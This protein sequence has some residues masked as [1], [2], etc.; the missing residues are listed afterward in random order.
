MDAMLE[1]CDAFLDLNLG[2]TNFGSKMLEDITQNPGN[3]PTLT[4]P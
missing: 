1:I 3:V 4:L 2:G